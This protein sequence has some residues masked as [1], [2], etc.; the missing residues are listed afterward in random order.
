MVVID[1]STLLFWTLD[2]QLL[3]PTAAVAIEDAERI[4]VS[5][6]SIWEIGI[7][8]S[9]GRLSIPVSV[10]EFAD[11]LLQI[12]IVEILPVDSDTW[13]QSIELRWEH[14]DPA[15]RVIVATAMLRGCPL[16]TS[17]AT[18]RRFYPQSIW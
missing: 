2:N 11:K 13:L 10:R 8:V 14:K 15:D 7:K 9:K 5:S 6:I 18:I 17:D 4:A 12:D 1:T 3:S 16:I